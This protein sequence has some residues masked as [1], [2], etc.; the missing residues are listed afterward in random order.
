ML[1]LQG[2]ERER[3]LRLCEAGGLA[4]DLGTCCFEFALPGVETCDQRTDYRSV[5]NNIAVMMG[6]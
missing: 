6:R 5:V 3:L 1:A 4:M 2:R